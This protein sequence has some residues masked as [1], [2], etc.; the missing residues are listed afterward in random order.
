M[1]DGRKQEREDKNACQKDLRH[2]PNP[3]K[4][5]QPGLNLGTLS[6]FGISIRFWELN[7]II[8]STDQINFETEFEIS[9]TASGAQSSRH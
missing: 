3:R 9:L 5:F 8:E 1:F 4:R 6:A 2:D 7:E